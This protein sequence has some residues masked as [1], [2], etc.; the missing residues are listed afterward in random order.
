MIKKLFVVIIL[1][2]QFN[3][4]FSQ[5]FDSNQLDT[6]FN[7]LEVNNKFM[8]S[9]A[10]YRDN[11]IIYNEQ[12]GFSEGSQQLKPNKN[13]KYRIASISKTFTAVLIF[14]AV[15]QGKL[16]LDETIDK[17]FP[18]IKNAHKIT[19]SNLL[20]HRSGIHSFTDDKKK[21]LS[22]YTEAKTEEEMLETISQYDSDFEPNTRAA[23]SNSNYLLL[24]YILEKTYGK[25]F[26]QILENELCIPLQLENTYFRELISI[27]NNEAYSFEFDKKWKKEVQTNE[28]IGLGA[29]GIISTPTDLIK[30]FDALFSGKVISN[31][32]LDKM[33]IIEDNF[34]MGLFQIT[35]YNSIS[36]GH[37]GGIDGFVSMVR[38]FPEEKM[39]FA[40]IANGLN[41][42][43]N[44]IE[45]TLVK[46]LL[47]KHFDI[48]IFTVYNP[49]SKELNQYLGKYSSETFPVKINVIT[50]KKQ[51]ILEVDGNEPIP[52]KSF[53]KGKFQSEAAGIIIE[54]LPNQNEMSIKQ[55]GKIN[56]LKR[57]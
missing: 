14:K 40:V 32:S 24:S 9:V 26:A 42:N 10:V 8:G 41:Y 52:L 20:N 43:F 19:I 15:E 47:N 2:A 7:T 36:F 55:D 12:F 11:K 45:T 34:G 51:L 30:F 17:Y 25:S 29:G 37:N 28:T 33:K 31:E 48:P 16:N 6:Y 57:Q 35:Y 13:T 3:I 38:Y 22:Y 18:T 54:F 44:A 39:A 27:E 21:Y 4:V 5:N 23:Y 56:I 50:S 1:I 49:S 53:E 46:Y